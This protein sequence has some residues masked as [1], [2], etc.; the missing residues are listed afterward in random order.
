MAKEGDFVYFDPPYHPM[1]TTASFT[2]Y[3]KY[4]FTAQDQKMLAEQ[5]K[6]LAGRGCYVML[7]N[8]N[9]EFIKSLYKGFN[10]LEVEANR[11]IN[12]KAEKRGKGLF[13]VLIKSW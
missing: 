6:A 2:K 12:C 1:S 9:T 8:S 4:D 10:I 11:F 3:S 7:S 13:E 5:F